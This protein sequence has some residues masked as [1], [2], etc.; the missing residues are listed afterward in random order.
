[1]LPSAGRFTSDTALFSQVNKLPC[2][3]LEKRIGAKEFH[4]LSAPD[5][6]PENIHPT[7]WAK[8][9]RK[10]EPHPIQA[11]ITSARNGIVGDQNTGVIE[12][13]FRK[14]DFMVTMILVSCFRNTF[15]NFRLLPGAGGQPA[16]LA[17]MRRRFLRGPR[18][19]LPYGVDGSHFAMYLQVLAQRARVPL[20]R[21]RDG[22]VALHLPPILPRCS[23]ATVLP[24]RST[25]NFSMLFLKPGTRPEHTRLFLLQLPP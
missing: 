14:L 13:A 11:Q 23:G 15:H 9:V 1:L 24:P 5:A 22:C 6:P 17:K 3:L 20:R 19:H 2:A 8:A 10:G 4:L 18:G 21:Q 25:L 16:G 7:L 12:E